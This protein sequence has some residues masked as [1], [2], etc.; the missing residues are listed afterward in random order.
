MGQ[1]SSVHFIRVGRDGKNWRRL[2]IVRRREF[3]CMGCSTRVWTHHPC[4][5][6]NSFH[7]WTVVWTKL[8]TCTS[9]VILPYYCI[10][11]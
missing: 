9:G 1:C 11:F 3:V 7:I 6:A 10:Y 8:D 5:Q 2:E 4:E